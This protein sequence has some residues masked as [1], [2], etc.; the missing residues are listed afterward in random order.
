MQCEFI[1]HAYIIA[2]T[3][4]IPALSKVMNIMSYNSYSDCRFCDI[5]RIYSEKHKHIYFPIDLK[6]I[7]IKKNNSTWLTCINK[8]KTAVI[9][10][11]KET[12]IK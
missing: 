8:I 6:K 11:E 4:N 5:K 12:L 10:K 3:G 1:F 9:I 2:Q 7:Y